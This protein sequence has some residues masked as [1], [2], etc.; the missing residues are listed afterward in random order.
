MLSFVIFSF[1][2]LAQ[3][4]NVPTASEIF[5]NLFSDLSIF[6]KGVMVGSASMDH[7]YF[8]VFIAYFILII[9]I[10]VEGIKY[11]PL[12]GSKGEISTPGKWFA[13]AATTLSVMAIF[14]AEQASGQSSQELIN[15]A[16][17][18]FGVWA[19]LALAGIFALIVFLAGK[20]SGLFE[21]H[22][23]L[24]ITYSLAVG[25]IFAGFFLSQANV[26]GWGYFI[27]IIAIVVGVIVAIVKH[28]NDT[29]DDGNTF[30][31]KAKYMDKGDGNDSPTTPGPE[32]PKTGKTLTKKLVQALRNVWRYNKKTTDEIKDALKELKRPKGTLK[33]A[34]EEIRAASR[35]EDKAINFDRFV[36]DAVGKIENV[37]TKNPETKEKLTVFSGVL[38]KELKINLKNKLKDA[39]NAKTKVKAKETL[40]EAL[41]ITQKIAKATSALK[42]IDNELIEELKKDS[43]EN[44]MNR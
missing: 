42:A 36:T 1:S 14:I 23:T 20:D 2:A 41:K 44:K 33:K 25:M 3:N 27:L 16:L 43:I 34:K 39:E 22:V 10:Y 13:F 19:G 32:N 7:T 30:F 15:M 29:P 12:F 35:Y 9:A 6:T 31:G 21:K 26:I 8:L 28:Y 37:I 11:L 38:E 18:P 4:G 17:A 5:K 40:E 24:G